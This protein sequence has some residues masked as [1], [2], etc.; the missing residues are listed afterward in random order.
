MKVISIR[1]ALHTFNSALKT[2]SALNSQ[3]AEAWW[4][5]WAFFHGKFPTDGGGWEQIV[6]N[7]SEE[8]WLLVPLTWCLGA[9]TRTSQPWASQHG[10]CCPGA[11]LGGD[12]FG[13]IP[14]DFKKKKGGATEIQARKQKCCSRP[15]L[16]QNR[17]GC[18]N[19]AEFPLLFGSLTQHCFHV[20]LL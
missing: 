3:C 11:M 14:T 16:S 5:N 17:F 2:T 8:A 7:R 6:K 20:V 9:Q 13:V 4:G 10:C 18:A 15:V 1:R 19:L 12:R